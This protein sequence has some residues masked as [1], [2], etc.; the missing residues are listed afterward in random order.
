VCFSSIIKDSSFLARFSAFMGSLLI[1][2]VLFSPLDSDSGL[3][4]T[5]VVMAFGLH[6]ILGWC[7]F[8][9]RLAA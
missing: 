2:F 8:P 4:R 5:G 7:H 3:H 1:C 6:W 9:G